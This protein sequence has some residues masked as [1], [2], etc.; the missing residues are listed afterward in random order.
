MSGSWSGSARSSFNTF[1]ADAV[2]LG[3]NDLRLRP[4]GFKWKSRLHESIKKVV[5]VQNLA[6]PVKP[7][8]VSVLR[9]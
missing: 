4:F 7:T 8:L 3:L 2:D 1:P 9:Y 5:Y 6:E